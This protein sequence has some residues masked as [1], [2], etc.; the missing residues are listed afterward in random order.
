MRPIKAQP[1]NFSEDFVRA[2]FLRQFFQ[3]IRRREDTTSISNTLRHRTHN[4]LAITPD[5]V[6]QKGVNY[7]LAKQLANDYADKMMD[8]WRQ[9]WLI[10]GNNSYNAEGGN[11]IAKEQGKTQHSRTFMWD[12]TTWK[13]KYTKDGRLIERGTVSTFLFNNAEPIEK[14]AS[15]NNSRDN[16]LNNWGIVLRT[17]SSN[18]WGFVLK[19]NDTYSVLFNLSEW[20]EDYGFRFATFNLVETKKIVMIHGSED[21]NYAY[22]EIGFTPISG[23]YGMGDS[24]YGGKGTRML[25]RYYIPLMG[26]KIARSLNFSRGGFQ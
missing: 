2:Y 26:A 15:V 13:Q 6:F 22:E 25:I 5:E 21:T 14:R 4:N 11:L 20:K 9:G 19:I 12:E 17:P 3:R 1:Q 8:L 7:G 10:I 23:G 24:A 16:I 18:Q